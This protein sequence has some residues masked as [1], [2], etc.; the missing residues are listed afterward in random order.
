[1][2][3]IIDK[4]MTN[5]FRRRQFTAADIK[6]MVHVGQQTILYLVDGREVTTSLPL[7]TVKENLPADIFWSIQKGIVISAR[8]TIS[9]DDN[10]LYTMVDGREFQGRSR[11]QAEHKRH[12]LMLNLPVSHMELPNPGVPYGLQQCA[13]MEHAPLPF[14]VIELAFAENGHSIDFV[15]RYCNKEMESLK[16]VSA[17]QL[18]D[19]SLYEVFPHGDRKWI[20]PYADVALNGNSRVVRFHSS[21]TEK[22]FTIHC[23]RPSPGYCACLLT[24]EVKQEKVS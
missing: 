19:R 15:F 2:E 3:Q 1:M 20:V 8:Y 13:L 17:D 12:R 14:C 4:R 5:L 21:K 23:F 24:E 10:G 11:N 18:I 6:Y 7:K 9:I 16:D 22:D